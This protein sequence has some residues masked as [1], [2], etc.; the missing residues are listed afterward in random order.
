MQ[1]KSRNNN[2]SNRWNR[3]Y[4]LV[5]QG[6]PPRFEK[7]NVKPQGLETIDK[8]LDVPTDMNQDH[9]TLLQCTS[10]KLDSTA[11]V[12][13]IVTQ[14]IKKL[15]DDFTAMMPSITKKAHGVVSKISSVKDSVEKI[16][17]TYA[18]ATG[19]TKLSTI[20]KTSIPRDISSILIIEKADP[21]YKNKTDIK[22]SFSKGFPEKQTGVCS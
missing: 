19:S 22:R 17:S 11:N 10:T 18:A 16:D 5:L 9:R 7:K 14:S 15:N 4:S 12:T 2:Q 13:T 3:N 6:M 1:G 20:I 21:P 8:K